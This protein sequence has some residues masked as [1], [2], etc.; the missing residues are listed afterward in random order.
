MVLGFTEHR[1]GIW[2][3]MAISQ[4]VTIS[5]SDRV[6]NKTCKLKRILHLEPSDPTKYFFLTMQKDT[7]F[8]VLSCLFRMPVLVKHTKTTFFPLA[9]KK[10][11]NR[12]Q[13]M[14]IGFLLDN[15]LHIPGVLLTEFSRLFFWEV[16]KNIEFIC[17]K[18]LGA[19]VNFIFFFL[20]TIKWIFHNPSHVWSP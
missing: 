10:S 5:G 1:V 11:G 16:D 20:R 4:N 15:D 2:G 9:F 13:H 18:Y 14:D 3:C 7:N 17:Q 8:S 6:Q 19:Q 12:H